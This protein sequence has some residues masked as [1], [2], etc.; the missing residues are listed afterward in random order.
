MSFFT[1]DYEAL[2]VKI[3]VSLLA[4]AE[5]PLTSDLGATI[6]V[7]IVNHLK[8]RAYD[9]EHMQIVRKMLQEIPNAKAP[10]SELVTGLLD[11]LMGL[12]LELWRGL[13]PLISALQTLD[14]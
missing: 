12:P 11:Y 10:V 14:K 8:L 13:S 4:R 5:M 6:A 9:A 7:Q 3:P 2:Q 1:E